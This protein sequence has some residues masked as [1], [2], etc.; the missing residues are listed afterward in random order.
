[1]LTDL[2]MDDQVTHP[3]LHLLKF[4]IG[5]SGDHGGGNSI[6][7]Y[8]ALE[9]CDEVSTE[10]IKKQS[11]KKLQSTH[12]LFDGNSR[13]VTTNAVHIVNTSKS[14]ARREHTGW[15]LFGVGLA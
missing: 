14:V 1:M 13:A 7:R 9:K 11:T 15:F 6:Q 10:V 3:P 4:S 2:V 8:P 12:L 5:T